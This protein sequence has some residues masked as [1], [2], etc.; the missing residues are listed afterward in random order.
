MDELHEKY[1][2]LVLSWI[3]RAITTEEK[4]VK[5]KDKPDQYNIEKE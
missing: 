5:D 3:N 4:P 2:A 1:Y